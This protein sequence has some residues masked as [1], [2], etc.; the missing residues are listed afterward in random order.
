MVIGEDG[1]V[2]IQF[3]RAEAI[4]DTEKSLEEKPIEKTEPVPDA[5]GPTDQI[6]EAKP[7]TPLRQDCCARRCGK[8]FLIM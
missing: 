1:N 2:S 3:P 4:I 8:S 5:F 6:W 7:E